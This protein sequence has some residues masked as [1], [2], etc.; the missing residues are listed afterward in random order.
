MFRPV[1]HPYYTLTPISHEQ[2]QLVKIF[3]GSVKIIVSL[4]DRLFGIGRL[5]WHDRYGVAES[6]GA[7]DLTSVSTCLTSHMVAENKYASVFL[8]SVNLHFRI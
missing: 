2:S 3:D 1:E 8:G 4:K 7:E 6:L 5:F